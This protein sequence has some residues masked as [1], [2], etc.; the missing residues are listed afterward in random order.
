MFR[1][2]EIVVH[3]VYLVGGLCKGQTNSQKERRV[4]VI[5]IYIYSLL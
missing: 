3:S 1:R 4:C 5:I 2:K